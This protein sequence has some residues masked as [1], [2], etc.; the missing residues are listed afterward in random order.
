MFNKVHVS[1][2]KC[3]TKVKSSKFLWSALEC[4]WGRITSPSTYIYTKVNVP[5]LNAGRPALQ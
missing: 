2:V 3:L 1:Y 4:G 5:A